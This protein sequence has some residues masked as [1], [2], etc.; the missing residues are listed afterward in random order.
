[1]AGGLHNDPLMSLPPLHRYVDDLAMWSE[2]LRPRA[3]VPFVGADGAPLD[4]FGALPTLPPPPDGPGRWDAPSPRPG[5][6]DPTVS[7]YV[8]AAAGARRGTAVLVPPWKLPRL[9][10]VSPWIRALAGAGMEVWTLVPPRHLHRAAPGTRNGEGFVS[11]ALPA[12]RAAVEQLVLEI[13]LLAALARAGGS[14]VGVVGL[15]LGALGAALAATGPEPLDFAALVAP[16]ADL[17]AVFTE[18]RIG[19]RYLRLARLAG[20]PPPP[21]PVLA[22]MLSPFRPDL[23]APTARRSLIVS[24]LEDGIALAASAAALARAW[25]APLSA[26]RR[27][28]LTLLFGCPAARREVARFAGG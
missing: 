17:A 7:A 28:H 20:A 18:T 25:E 24:G 14:R 12:L 16:P 6:G 22:A 19:R 15:S 21:A 9:G 11:P 5:G 13:R 4:C 1:V 26:H 23:R 10:L 3:P 2:D 8:T 27:G